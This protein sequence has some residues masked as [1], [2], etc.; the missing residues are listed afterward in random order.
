MILYL[1]QYLQQLQEH[2]NTESIK[3]L[4]SQTLISPGV[5]QQPRPVHRGTSHLD[6]R[7]ETRNLERDS[8]VHQVDAMTKCETMQNHSLLQTDKPLV[9]C[10][11]KLYLGVFSFSFQQLRNSYCFTVSLFIIRRRQRIPFRQKNT[12]Y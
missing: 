6:L 4:R 10:T 1:I 3:C 7:A 8:S 5:S 9:T 2:A 12:L 11:S